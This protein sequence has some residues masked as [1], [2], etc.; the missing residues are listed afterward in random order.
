MVFD[1]I[2]EPVYRHGFNDTTK[3][4]CP[5]FLIKYKGQ[6][7]YLE[8]FGISEEGQNTRFTSQEFIGIQKTH[9]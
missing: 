6:E 3:P 1:Y 8:H 7:I 2:Y 9:Q 4:Y 5:D